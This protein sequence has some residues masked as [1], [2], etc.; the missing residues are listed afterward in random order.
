MAGPVGWTVERLNGAADGVTLPLSGPFHIRW[1]PEVSGAARRRIETEFGLKEMGQVTRDP[2]HRTWEY[3]LP[4][5]TKAR[6]RALVTH[7]AV[8]DTARVDILRF[9]IAQ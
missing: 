6:V 9:E 2:R 1:K 4:T 8:E 5:P 3:R 7:P